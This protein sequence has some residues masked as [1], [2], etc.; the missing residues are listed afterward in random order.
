M[1]GR[2]TL[3]APGPRL[4]ELFEAYAAPLLRPRFNIAPSQPVAAVRLEDRRRR[5]VEL[6]WGLVPSWADDPK[7]GFRLINARSETAAAKPSFRAAFKS[8]RCLIPADG[9]YEWRTDGKLKQPY[10]IALKSGE[11]FALAG[12]WE[13]WEKAGELIESCTILTTETNERL[14]DLHDRMPAVLPKE[15]Y[16]G[17][18][19]SESKPEELK[20]LLKPAPNSWWMA[21]AVSSYVNS[22]A[23]EGERCLADA[24]PLPP[25]LEQGSLF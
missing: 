20:A 11:P 3:R 16:A 21:R 13:R 4:A 24:A 9:W 5:F 15:A 22:A 14:R 12:L 10:H 23:H 17:W 7:I 19:A 25:K 6:R 8:R 2:Y 18:L 1:C